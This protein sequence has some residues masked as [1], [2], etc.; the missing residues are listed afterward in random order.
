MSLLRLLSPQ[1]M[2]GIVISLALGVL[3]LVQKGET[4]HGKEQSGRF[5]QLYDEEK[6]AFAATLASYRAAAD[7]ARAADQANI[8]RVT[9]QQRAINEG[10]EHDYETRLAAARAL[11]RSVR[12]QTGSAAAGSGTGRAAPVRGLAAA[13]A[14]PDEASRQDR[15]SDADAL[16]ATEQAIQ[17]DEL[18]KWIE[19]QHSIPPNAANQDRPATAVDSLRR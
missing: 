4:R 7:A 5:E 8:A 19:R 17:L 11:A 15:L 13:A 16:V 2:A 3:L 9:A 12:G 10:T 14:E 1:G 18:I 6:A